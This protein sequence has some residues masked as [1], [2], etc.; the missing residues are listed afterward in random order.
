M[1]TCP[2][3]QKPTRLKSRFHIS[4]HNCTLSRDALSDGCCHGKARACQMSQVE[5]ARNSLATNSPKDS[6]H[7][8]LKQ[9]GVVTST[10]LWGWSVQ[11][12][13]QSKNITLLSGAVSSQMRW[14]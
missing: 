10:I 6:R 12:Y 11:T 2:R 13:A 5:H 7:S 4:S 9:V 3:N 8:R 14:V 1:C